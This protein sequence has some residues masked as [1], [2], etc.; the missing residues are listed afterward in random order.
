MIRWTRLGLG[1][2]GSAAFQLV[3]AAIIFTAGTFL[4]DLDLK[5]A[6]IA[7][8]NVSDLHVCTIGHHTPPPA[9]VIPQVADVCT[10]LS[11]RSS[12]VVRW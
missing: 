1:H 4:L 5:A 2:R 10:R 12:L 6:E 9:I 7:L 3:A 11:A 8:I